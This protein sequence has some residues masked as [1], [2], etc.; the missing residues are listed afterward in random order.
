MFRS[1]GGEGRRA[2]ARAR[3]LGRGGFTRAVFA[4]THVHAS[5]CVCAYARARRT[6]PASRASDADGCAT[7]KAGPPKRPPPS[8]P[9][10]APR[11]HARAGPG[12]SGSGFGTGRLAVTA[13]APVTSA[14]T[15]SMLRA[16]I[17]ALELGVS[18]PPFRAQTHTYK[19][20]LGKTISE[21]RRQGKSKRNLWGL[22]CSQVRV[23]TIPRAR[24][25][26]R[27]HMYSHTYTYTYTR[28]YARTHA[29]PR[30]RTH[31]KHARA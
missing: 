11:S 24:T 7:K 23:H 2:R 21:I 13:P 8:T 17:A 1:T 25:R 10:T 14:A 6:A 19:Q 4:R 3:V 20:D 26:A 18:I 16:C 27:T 22:D 31:T 30:P 12:N 9:P 28:I 5:V 15:E 29:R